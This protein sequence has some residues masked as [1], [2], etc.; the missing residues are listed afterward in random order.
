[1]KTNYAGIANEYAKKETAK[2][3]LIPV[4]YNG[5]TTWQTQVDQGPDAFLEA[6][7]YMELYDI[8]TDSEAYKNGVYISEKITESSSPQAV[9]D[10]VYDRI[11]SY[12][13]TNKFVTVVAGER[14]TS[15]GTIKAFNDHFENLTVLQFDAHAHLNKSVNGE[16]VNNACAMY[17]ASQ[18]T[19]LV[20]VGIRSMAHIE[21]TVIDDDKVFYANDLATDDYWMENALEIMSDNVFISFDLDSLDPSIMPSVANPE[22]GGLFWFETLE[23]LYKVFNEKNVVGFDLVGLCPNPY[24]KAPNALAARLYYKMLS[25]KFEMEGEDDELGI[26]ESDFASKENKF[27]KFHDDLD[28]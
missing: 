5:T 14:S 19:N 24:N 4:T 23:F 10:Q 27:G 1:M 11:K 18:A 22:Q 16:K 7:E 21:K 2:I 26:S 8:E 13:N 3:V 9:V 12:L 28:A 25:Y 17:H 6:S 20:Q 15:I